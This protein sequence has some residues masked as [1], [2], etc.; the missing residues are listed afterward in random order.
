MEEIIKAIQE[1]ANECA[2]LSQ[3]RD[4]YYD[5]KNTAYLD[6]IDMLIEINKPL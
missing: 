5:G 4:D 2:E 3:H 6:V 1:R